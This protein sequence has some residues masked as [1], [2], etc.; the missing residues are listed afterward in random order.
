MID[1]PLRVL[2]EAD[3]C[4]LRDLLTE[5][6]REAKVALEAATAIHAQVAATSRTRPVKAHEKAAVQVQPA[7]IYNCQPH[8]GPYQDVAIRSQPHAWLPIMQGLL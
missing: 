8:S 1:S 3:Q 5:K 2:R 6:K 4:R 7:L